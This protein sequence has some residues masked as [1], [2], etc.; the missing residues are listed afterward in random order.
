MVYI[1]RSE[2][3][4]KICKKDSC[5]TIPRLVSSFRSCAG[6]YYYHLLLI[7]PMII[8]FLTTNSLIIII[9]IINSLIIIPL[10]TSD[11]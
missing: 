1:C 2:T 6:A 8:N 7:N 5:T 9:L 11:P 3:L 4:L 10:I